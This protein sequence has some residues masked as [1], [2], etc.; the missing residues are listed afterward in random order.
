MQKRKATWR[1]KTT[2]M[3]QGSSMQADMA[4]DKACRRLAPPMSTDNVFDAVL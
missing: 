3:T 1:V 2:K 4:E